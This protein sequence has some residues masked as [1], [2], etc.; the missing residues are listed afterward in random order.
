MK[1]YRRALRVH[2]Y[3][4]V[5]GALI[6][7]S[8][9]WFFSGYEVMNGLTDLQWDMMNI[10]NLSTALF[11]VFLASLSFIVLRYK[12]LEFK[13]IRIINLCLLLFYSGRL[14]IEF[15]IPSPIPFIII[16][17]SNIVIRIMLSLLILILLYPEIKYKLKN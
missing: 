11:F 6:H 8:W 17:E 5:L 3:F 1:T 4:G 14:L 2:A 15:I 13:S 9:H 10:F 7:T 12:K 16:E